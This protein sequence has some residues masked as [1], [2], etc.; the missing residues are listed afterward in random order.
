MLNINKYWN[1]P[2][3]VVFWCWVFV[4]SSILT[5]NFV[6]V[7]FYFLGSWF[8]LSIIF[9]EIFLIHNFKT[10]LIE[11][12]IG[13]LIWI[14]IRFWFYI[15][16]N[17]RSNSLGLKY[18]LKYQLNQQKNYIMFIK[19]RKNPDF[20]FLIYTNG[21]WNINFKKSGLMLA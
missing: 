16:T 9:D 7:F 11:I 20:L 10:M 5:N 4:L 2:F 6:L 3:F 21:K 13:Y 1:L 15:K 8:C 19:G 18:Y 14:S 17:I 12:I